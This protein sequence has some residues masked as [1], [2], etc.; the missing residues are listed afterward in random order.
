MDA[1]ARTF[2][3]G[4]PVVPNL[5]TAG[6]DGRFLSAAGIPTYGVPGIM[7]GAGDSGAHGI[8]ERVPVR[9]VLDGRDY[10]HALIRRLSSMREG[11]GYAP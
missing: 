2:F 11:P 4:V 7:L 9:S 5:L 3:P 10:L 1:E 6:T 8:N